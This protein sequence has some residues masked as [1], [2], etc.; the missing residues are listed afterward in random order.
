M[1]R[2]TNIASRLHD[3]AR[4][5]PELPAVAQPRRRSRDG[6]YRYDVWTFGE[7]GAVV[8]HLSAGLRE[9][10]VPSGARMVLFVPF[11]REF[12]ALTFALFRIGAVVVLIDPGMGRA[13][14]FRCLEEVRPDGFVAVPDSA[15]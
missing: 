7:F 11:S 6:T 10:G 9:M 14:I 2:P 13:N 1:S 3:A 15:Q 4:R 12:L 8:G 5:S